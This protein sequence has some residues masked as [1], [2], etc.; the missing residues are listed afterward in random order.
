MPSVIQ[1]AQLYT[2]LFKTEQ[3]IWRSP[4]FS[5]FSLVTN[6]P[7]LKGDTLLWRVNAQDAKRGAGRE[8]TV[9]LIES[10]S[11]VTAK[12]R[13]QRKLSELREEGFTPSDE[14]N[15]SME[16]CSELHA[17]KTIAYRDVVRHSDENKYF[18]RFYQLAYSKLRSKFSLS[19]APH[20]GHVAYLLAASDIALGCETG[21]LE[22]LGILE[23]LSSTAIPDKVSAPIRS[24]IATLG[25]VQKPAA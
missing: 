15:L 20:P 7:F 18:Q 22:S 23:P 8:R 10:E 3:M 12:A 19:D 21:I 16:L 17:Q 24:L 6:R 4:D 2:S 14:V 11:R 5:E 13:F 1:E 9:T 25:G